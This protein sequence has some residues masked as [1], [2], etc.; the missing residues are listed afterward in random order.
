MYFDDT[1]PTLYCVQWTVL[2]GTESPGRGAP[3]CTAAVLV[4]LVLRWR[5]PLKRANIKTR[6]KKWYTES[7]E[8][9]RG[10]SGRLSACLWLHVVRGPGGS[11]LCHSDIDACMHAWMGSM[12]GCNTLSCLRLWV[13]FRMWDH[14]WDGKLTLPPLCASAARQVGVRACAACLCCVHVLPLDHQPC[15]VSAV[16]WPKG[17]RIEAMCLYVQQIPFMRPRSRS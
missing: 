11:A 13:R 12:A 14:W 17:T 6:I 9:R 2:Y 16:P 15:S 5:I 7:S 10:E 3:C 4:L 8:R 1:Y